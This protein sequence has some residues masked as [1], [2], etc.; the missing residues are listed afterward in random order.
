MSSDSSLA[1]LAPTTLSVIYKTLGK[2]HLDPD[3][4][5]NI[6]SLRRLLLTRFPRGISLIDEPSSMAERPKS[7]TSGQLTRGVAASDINSKMPSIVG[8]I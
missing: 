6:I 4:N 5:N 2:K 8:D 1:Q 3:D 7:L